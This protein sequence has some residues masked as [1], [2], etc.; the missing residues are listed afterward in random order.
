MVVKTSIRKTGEQRRST[1]KAKDKIIEAATDL[2][3]FEGFKSTTVRQIAKKA[4]VNPALVSYYFGSKKGLLE[5]LMVNFYESYFEVLESQRKMLSE[6][7]D[8]HHKLLSLVNVAFNYLFESYKMTRFIYRELTLDSM[9]IR[10]VMS[11]YISKEKYYYLSVMEEALEKEQI[12]AIDIEMVV[13]QIL[14]ILYMP[15]LQPQV[16]REVYHMEPLSMT[17]K[18]RYYDQLSGWIT[19]YLASQTVQTQTLHP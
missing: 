9:L 2:F 1:Q 3:Y 15:F 17:F 4:S 19:F 10:E 13:L 14:N 16:I 8:V 7:Q 5:A 12:S 18:K 6:Q 11:T